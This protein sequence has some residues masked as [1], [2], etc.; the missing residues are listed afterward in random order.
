MPAVIAQSN[1][2]YP[3]KEVATFEVTFRGN[4]GALADTAY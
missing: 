3:Y 2:A 1:A 4:G